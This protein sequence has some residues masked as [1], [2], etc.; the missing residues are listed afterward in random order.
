MIYKRT[1][2]RKKNKGKILDGLVSARYR[3]FPITTRSCIS[4]ISAR[5]GSI[6]GVIL[7]NK[8]RFIVAYSYTYRSAP[9]SRGRTGSRY[10]ESE[11][12]VARK[13]RIEIGEYAAL[14]GVKI[15]ARACARKKRGTRLM[16]APHDLRK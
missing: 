15:G 13:Y 10:V 4:T 6:S 1:Y 7:I 2:K 5:E 12:F 14:H 8:S 11:P 9:G 16:V 3:P